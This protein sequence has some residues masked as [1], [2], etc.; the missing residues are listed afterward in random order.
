MTD[1]TEKDDRKPFGERL[2]DARESLGLSVDEM[3]E[4]L[5]L[6]LKI[7]K[8]LESSAVE[9]LPPAIYVQGYIKAYTKALGIASEE[10]HADFLIYSRQQDVDE[11]QPSSKVPHETNSDTP[12]VK[13]TSVLFVLLAISGIAFG[14]YSYYAAK[15]DSID[16][17]ASDAIEIDGDDELSMPGQSGSLDLPVRIEPEV[18]P[19]ET[20]IETEVE[21]ATTAQVVVVDEKPVVE[22]PAAAIPEAVESQ[23]V[24]DESVAA[25][26]TLMI[27]ATAESWAEIRDAS[28][29]RIYFDMLK[30]D[31]F[32]TLQGS[33][34]FDVFLGN[35]VVV[36]I[37]VNDIDVDMSDHIRAN[38]VAHFKV[39]EDS[40]QIVFH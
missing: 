17:P 20:S 15:V 32:L 14:I 26:D 33:A 6:D 34:P 5:N 25:G 10:I 1:E 9:Q 11:L 23:A 22:K 35:A 19:E 8:A 3:A 27:R 21:T 40:G 12:I 2:S 36:D 16:Q 31:E 13:I 18:Q 29:S 38:N 4:R 37:A 7:L 30:E 28:K 39:S 24:A